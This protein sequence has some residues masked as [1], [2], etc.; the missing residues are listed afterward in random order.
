MAWKAPTAAS[1]SRQEPEMRRNLRKLRQKSGMMHRLEPQRASSDKEH[2]RRGF[3]RV[4]AEIEREM[5]IGE[6]SLA[7]AGTQLSRGEEHCTND[8]RR[9][10]RGCFDRKPAFHGVLS[11]T[12][13]RARE[14]ANKCCGAV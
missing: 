2:C 9:K 7:L 10:L 5:T 6:P 3:S 1:E 4:Q 8:G 11:S 13:Q 14:S 12:F